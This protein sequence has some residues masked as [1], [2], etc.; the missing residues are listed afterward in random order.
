MITVKM[1]NSVY[2]IQYPE[3]KPWEYKILH[4]GKDVTKE[5]GNNL[6]LDIVLAIDSGDLVKE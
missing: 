1:E 2:T 6:I 5:L 3:D 4:H